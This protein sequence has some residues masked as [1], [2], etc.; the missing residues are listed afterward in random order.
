MV[1]AG[2]TISRSF[3]YANAGAMADKAMADAT[4]IVRILTVQLRCLGQDE[5]L[6]GA[7]CD[8]NSR[9][10]QGATASQNPAFRSRKCHGALGVQKK[11]IGNQILSARG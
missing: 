8:A 10:A 1:D 3:S 11:T 2:L 6:A 5:S 9:Q 7:A 4:A